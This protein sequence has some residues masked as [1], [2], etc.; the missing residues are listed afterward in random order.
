[1]LSPKEKVELLMIHI[2]DDIASLRKI[3][4][5]YAIE[6]AELSLPASAAIFKLY[7]EDRKDKN[8]NKNIKAKEEKVLSEPETLGVKI[9]SQRT[10]DKF[11]G[12][13]PKLM[14][15]H[16][17]LKMLHNEIS[18]EL[19]GIGY[20]RF[21]FRSLIGQLEK[22]LRIKIPGRDELKPFVHALL[23]DARYTMKMEYN[24]RIKKMEAAF[25]FES[26][27]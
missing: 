9:L 1:M 14:I 15:K 7:V 3:V 5:Q 12:D 17:E 13:F 22:R 26:L 2:P 23:K 10:V 19:R 16:P 21:T 4:R 27:I 6:S 8:F 24:P 18:K 20:E 25:Y 11:R